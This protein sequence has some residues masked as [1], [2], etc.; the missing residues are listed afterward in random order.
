V[1]KLGMKYIINIQVTVVGYLYIMDLISA[2]KMEHIKII[3]IILFRAPTVSSIIQVECKILSRF[4]FWPFL[5]CSVQ[6]VSFFRFQE[7]KT[8]NDRNTQRVCNFNGDKKGA[9]PTRIRISI[10]GSIKRFFLLHHVQNGSGAHPAYYSTGIG[11]L[12][13]S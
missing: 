9:G 13:M 4:Q 6:I 7:R 2:L 3:S 11:D 12:S 1:R 5:Q 10:T 8:K